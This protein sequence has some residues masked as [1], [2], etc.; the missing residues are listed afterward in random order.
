MGDAG[1]ERPRLLL[2]KTA[3]STIGGANSGARNAPNTP[4][5]TQDSD[6]ALV[7]DRWPN[8]PEHIKATVK[9]LIQI[10]SK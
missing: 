7:V 5:T 2:S 4:Q 9:A 1:L 10:N 8:L 6:L 3:I